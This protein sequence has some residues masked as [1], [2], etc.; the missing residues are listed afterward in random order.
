MLYD[1][2]LLAVGFVLVAAGGNLF[3]DSSVDIAR[4]LRVSRMVIGGSI[5]SFATTVPELFVSATASSMGD[6][7]IALGNAVGSVIANIGLI[8]GTVALVTRISVDRQAYITRSAW[9]CGAAVLVIL[10]SWTGTI[11]RPLAAVLLGL[12]LAY[13]YDEYR[14]A[15]KHRSH[16]A[17]ED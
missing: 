16:V 17:P 13:F 1:I 11:S 6:S 4:A 12:S 10:F 14:R 15:R 3:V 2:G 9:M 5:V 7:G 8:I